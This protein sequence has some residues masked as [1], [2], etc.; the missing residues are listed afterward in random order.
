M[1]VNFP[2]WT[3][4][5]PAIAALAVVGGGLTVVLTVWYFFSPEFTDVGYTPHQPIAYSH[6]LHAGLMGMD[7]RYCHVAV[8]LGPHA[9]VPTTEVCMNCHKTV[10]TDSPEIQK[11]A[12]A[13]DSGM[14]V[15][16]KKVHLLP[17]YAFFNHAAHVR[18]G[19]GCASCHGRVD[20]MEE[21]RQ[22]KA[23]SMAWCLECHRAPET[24]LRPTDRVTD[25]AW[26]HDPDL[27][28]R[29]RD[30]KQIAPP[31]HCSACHR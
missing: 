15:R 31:T 6:K 9:T 27:A 10:R 3:N 26:T 18:V 30:E 8:E 23:L 5:L 2:K 14:P 25:M 13:H 17:D 11:L 7:C 1:T 12:V 28:Q 16:W 4:Q 29:L 24:A 21:V 19:V 20:Q 22:E